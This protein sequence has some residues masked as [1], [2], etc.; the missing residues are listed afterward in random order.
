MSDQRCNRCLGDWWG[1]REELIVGAS[2]GTPADP[3][4]TEPK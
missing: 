2:L 3:Q 4:Q 1:N